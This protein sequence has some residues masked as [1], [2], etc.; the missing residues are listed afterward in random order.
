MDIGISKL[1]H[2]EGMH[3][4]LNNMRVLMHMDNLMFTLSLKKTFKIQSNI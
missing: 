2:T 1:I 4:C 3:I